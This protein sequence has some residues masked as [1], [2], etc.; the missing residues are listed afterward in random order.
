MAS[1]PVVI[2]GAQITISWNNVQYKEIADISF[3]IDYGEEPIYGID[4][5]Y[6]QEIAGGKIMVSG[7]VNG[8]RLKNS[9]GLEAK[10]LRS[11]FT[12]VTANPYVSLLVV[13]RSTQENIL[14]VPQCKIANQ[15]HSIPNRGTYKLN[16][17]FKGMIALTAMD[18]A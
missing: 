15:T 14:L 6:A 2:T 17:S 5:Q 9:G 18:R 3:T 12:D 7:Q 11:L 1:L 4:S 16:F 8:F 10:N 13:D